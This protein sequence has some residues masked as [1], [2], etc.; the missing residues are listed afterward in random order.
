MNAYIFNAD[1]YCADCG[2]E[3]IDEYRERGIADNGDSN[4]YPQGPYRIG[5]EGTPGN[6]A[7]CCSNTPNFQKV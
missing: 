4:T 6:Q 1:I 7:R 5:A 3:M 2:Q